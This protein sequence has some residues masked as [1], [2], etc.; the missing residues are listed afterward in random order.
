MITRCIFYN[1]SH[2]RSWSMMFCINGE[3]NTLSAASEYLLSALAVRKCFLIPTI[4]Y[5]IGMINYVLPNG[6]YVII[7]STPQP[8]WVQV[9][10]FI[11]FGGC[12]PPE[13]NCRLR[14]DWF[15]A[16]VIII[17]R[18]ASK[19]TEIKAEFTGFANQYTI[20]IAVQILL[21][22]VNCVNFGS[23]LSIPKRF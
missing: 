12:C 10:E 14:M 3:W 5:C 9:Q 21:P 4:L 7:C 18:R 1:R 13:L 8:P 22:H 23:I 6:S 15:R 20:Y 11:V 2:P 17:E 19:S 16:I